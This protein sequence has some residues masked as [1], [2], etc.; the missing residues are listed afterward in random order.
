[1]THTVSGVRERFFFLRRSGK[2]CFC[3]SCVGASEFEAAELKGAVRGLHIMCS[4][5]SYTNDPS[6]ENIYNFLVQEFK[7]SSIKTQ[8]H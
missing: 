3:A 2:I 6:L 7:A 5:F 4:S 1:M 8:S